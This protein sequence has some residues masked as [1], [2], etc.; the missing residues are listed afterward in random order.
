MMSSEVTQNF[1]RFPTIGSPDDVIKLPR[2]DVIIGIM[3]FQIG[4][5]SQWALL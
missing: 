4:L 1:V 5:A 3:S 2:C